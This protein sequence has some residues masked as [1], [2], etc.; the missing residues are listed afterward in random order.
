[1]LLTFFLRFKFELP[2]NALF[3]HEMCFHCFFLF[4]FCVFLFSTFLKIDTVPIATPLIEIKFALIE[5]KFACIVILLQYP[6][7]M[8]V[9]LLFS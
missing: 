5:I 4:L 1:M 2:K 7:E 8:F 3:L 9:V 6:L